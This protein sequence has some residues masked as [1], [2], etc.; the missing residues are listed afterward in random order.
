MTVPSGMLEIARRPGACQI[1]RP[2]QIDLGIENTRKWG[3]VALHDQNIV[4][5]RDSYSFKIESQWSFRLHFS[6]GQDLYS[7]PIRGTGYISEQSNVVSPP[8]QFAGKISPGGL[9]A[10]ETLIC[11]HISVNRHAGDIDEISEH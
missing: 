9:G 5:Y 1:M 3:G 10:P 6:D 4:R 7:I 11:H 8:H 2:P